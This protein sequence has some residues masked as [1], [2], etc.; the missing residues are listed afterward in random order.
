MGPYEDLFYKIGTD[1]K[2]ISVTLQNCC[3][4]SGILEL[5]SMSECKMA[6]MSDC[7]WFITYA[8]QDKNLCLISIDT[9]KYVCVPVC[10][11]I[12]TVLFVVCSRDYFLNTQLCPALC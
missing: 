7:L 2:N 9:H 6:C 12:G 5:E 3:L 11:S 1:Q 8:F 10:L 4:Y